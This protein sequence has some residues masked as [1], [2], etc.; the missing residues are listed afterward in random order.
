M[1]GESNFVLFNESPLF[2]VSKISY[3]IDKERNLE[4]FDL[5]YSLKV[6]RIYYLNLKT[7]FLLIAENIYLIFFKIFI[8]N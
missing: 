5:L 2:L 8:K 7:Q 3:S 1:K 6:F 4:S